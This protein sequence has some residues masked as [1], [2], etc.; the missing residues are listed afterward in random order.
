MSGPD[1]DMSPGK[2]NWKKNEDRGIGLLGI[3]LISDDP[4][5]PRFAVDT[6]GRPSP[7]KAFDDR[8]RRGMRTWIKDPLAIFAEGAE[9]GIV[10]RGDADRGSR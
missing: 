2:N 8:G 4:R 1:M 5:S 7:K 9:R 3:S 6:A 10:R